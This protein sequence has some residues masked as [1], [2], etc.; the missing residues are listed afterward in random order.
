MNIVD[1]KVHLREW[2]T[3]VLPDHGLAGRLLASDKLSRWIPGE[4]SLDKNTR[5]RRADRMGLWKMM[6]PENQGLG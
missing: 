3:V 1:D 5:Y 6:G 2:M 4:T